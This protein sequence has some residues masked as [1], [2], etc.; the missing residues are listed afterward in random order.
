MTSREAVERFSRELMP[1]VTA[2]PPGTTGYAEGRPRV[3]PLFR[4]W[5]CLVGRD[6]VKP[7]IEMFPV[8]E[9][10]GPVQGRSSRERRIRDTAHWRRPATWGRMPSMP[11]MRQIGNLPHGG[12]ATWPTPVAATRGSMPISASSPEGRTIFPSCAAK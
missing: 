9:D 11:I 4:F 12:S 10:A 8:V 5:P 7:Q 2:G 1:L 3:H 6:C